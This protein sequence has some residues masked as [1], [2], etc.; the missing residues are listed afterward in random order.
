MTDRGDAPA[1]SAL[2]AWLERAPRPLFVA[3][4]GGVAFV[5]YFSMYAFRKPFAAAAFEGESFFD[6]GLELKTALIL[7]QL[8]GY[9]LSKYVGVRLVSEVRRPSRALLASIA[10]AELALVGFALLPGEAGVLALFFNGLPLGL[11]WGLVVR[12][13]EGRRQSE[14]LLTMLSASFIVASGAVKDVGRAVMASGV[15]ERWMPAL[16]G[17]LFLVPFVLA[18]LLLEQLPPPDAEDVAARTARTPMSAAERRRFLRRFPAALG[19]LFV[20]YFFLT[21]YRDFRDMYGVEIFAGLGYGDEPALFTQTELP[22]AALVLL[23][24]GSLQF[25][26]DNRR[27][28][29]GGYAIMVAGALLLG[30]STALHAA[31]S[32]DGATWM[33][34]TGLGSYLA[35]VPLGSVL[36]DRWVAASGVAGTAVFAIYVADALGYTGSVLVQVLRDALFGGLPRLEFFVGFTWAMSAGGVV[37]LVGSGVSLAR[38]LGSRAE[39][40]PPTR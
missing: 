19:L 11:V 40:S 20:V 8:L 21:A 28:L 38:R 34:A 16:V 12:H 17:A 25:V 4:A 23:T 30:G 9:A 5:A 15:S 27:A 14:L 13:L 29:L 1:R 24:L 7:G 31:G 2:T 39:L 37:L 6:T 18:T 36:F 33:V 26:R 32:I 10:L 3:Y 22:V 35:Y